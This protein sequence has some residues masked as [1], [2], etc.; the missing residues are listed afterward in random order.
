M[1]NTIKKLLLTGLAFALTTTPV[2]AK[3]YLDREIPER[4]YGI[5]ALIA[6]N[7]G[8]TRIVSDVIVKNGVSFVET[9]EIAKAFNLIAGVIE[10][11]CYIRT[12]DPQSHEYGAEDIRIDYNLP[13]K[14]LNPNKV[15]YSIQERTTVIPNAINR[16][17][18][19]ESRF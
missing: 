12:S 15:S 1:K 16:Y 5:S 14:G 11:G 19:I 9:T 8:G 3:T 7:K 13:G 6:E 17:T 10:R 2:F 4:A 18:G